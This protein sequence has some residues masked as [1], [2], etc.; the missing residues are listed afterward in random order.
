MKLSEGGNLLVG[1]LE[2][3]RKRKGRRKGYEQF[4]V[5]YYDDASQTERILQDAFQ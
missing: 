4:K 5:A 2:D 1:E 3:K